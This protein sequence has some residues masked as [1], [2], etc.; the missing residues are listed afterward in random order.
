MNTDRTWIGFCQIMSDY[1]ASFDRCSRLL[2]EIEAVMA[3][4]EDPRVSNTNQLNQ[5]IVDWW[6]AL[7]ELT[8]HDTHLSSHDEWAIADVFYWLDSYMNSLPMKFD[9]PN[10][11]VDESKVSDDEIELLVTRIW[12]STHEISDRAMSEFYHRRKT[13]RSL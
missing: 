5:F 6:V 8:S 9:M 10:P 4:D 12:H 2:E 11:R 3:H 13:L 1:A 7:K